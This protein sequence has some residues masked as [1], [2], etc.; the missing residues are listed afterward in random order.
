MICDAMRGLRGG[1]ARQEAD[2]LAARYGVT[3][4]SIYRMTREV[5]PPRKRRADRETRSIENLDPTTPWGYCAGLVV[6][7]EFAADLALATGRA[8]GKDLGVS[9][10][11]F[12]RWLREAGASRR[13]VKI[14]RRPCR[15]FEAARPNDLWQMDF[16]QAAQY[17]IADDGGISAW[18]V[19]ERR[20]NKRGRIPLVVACVV[21]DHSRARYRRAYPTMRKDHLLDFLQHSFS[22]KSDP[23]HPLCGLPRMI[24]SDN[25]SIIHNG[26]VDEALDFLAIGHDAHL[27]VTD[28]KPDAARG[29]GKVERAFRSLKEAEKITHLQKWQSLD[30]FNAWLFEDDIRYGNQEH[31]TTGD[32]PFARWSSIRADELRL[33]PAD[34]I[35][36]RLYFREKASPISAHLTIRPGDG[37]EW[38]LP[39][40]E[41]FI[42]IMQRGEKLDYFMLPKDPDRIL[43]LADGVEHEVRYKPATIDVARVS[44]GEVKSV[45]A[46]ALDQAR[47]VL[48]E[49][50]YRG[51]A[52]PRPGDG[53]KFPVWFRPAGAQFDEGKME[54]PARAGVNRVEAIDRLQKRGIVATPIT[55]EERA[56]VDALFAA[57][58]EIAEDE[59]TEII[60]RRA[61]G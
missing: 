18:G 9:V 48:G 25:D 40:A 27:P 1:R 31:G 29:T 6:K 39:F 13:H 30:E 19:G 55:A 5:R 24:Y 16:T 43:A 3:R 4:A 59:L 23:R 8:N 53:E 14:Y 15:R 28:A 50:S 37:R 60:R 46:T 44:G 57:R 2:R 11:T 51:D 34:E 38:Q 58:A 20:E 21:D 61:A 47:A 41:P 45:A 12:R 42:G 7:H 10:A 56:W 32:M 49:H 26:I 52:I 33:P 35:F 22:P 17:Y 54:V 36:N